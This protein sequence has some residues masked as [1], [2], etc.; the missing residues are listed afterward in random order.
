VKSAEEAA[1]RLALKVTLR[2]VNEESARVDAQDENLNPVQF[3]MKKMD[4]GTKVTFV[5]GSEKSE[6]N[7][8]LA[9]RMKSEFETASTSKSN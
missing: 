4:S 5:A 1:K 9:R 6:A 2:E 3:H 8:D 7:R